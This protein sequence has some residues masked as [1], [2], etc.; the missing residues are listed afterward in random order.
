MRRLKHNKILKTLE[1]DTK[2]HKNRSYLLLP[3]PNI[4]GEGMQ[5]EDSAWP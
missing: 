1:S 4:E 3:M 5:E 2:R